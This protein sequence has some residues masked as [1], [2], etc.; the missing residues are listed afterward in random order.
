M[1][2]LVDLSASASWTI[3]RHL[4]MHDLVDSLMPPS[5]VGDSFQVLLYIGIGSPID[6]GPLVIEIGALVDVCELR[7][8]E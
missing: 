4:K 8:H 2:I 3:L 5:L 6:F 1:V 7:H